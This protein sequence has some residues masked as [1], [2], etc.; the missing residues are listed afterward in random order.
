MYRRL[1]RVID[2]FSFFPF[3]LGQRTI[4]IEGDTR[5]QLSQGPCGRR[6]DEYARHDQTP[7]F[8]PRHGRIMRQSRKARQEGCYP[9]RGRARI[10]AF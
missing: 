8:D 4:G 5:R 2:F 6:N 10:K 9:L 7:V 1:V 3:L